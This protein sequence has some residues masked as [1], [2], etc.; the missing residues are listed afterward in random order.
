MSELLIGEGLRPYVDEDGLARN[1]ADYP[2]MKEELSGLDIERLSVVRE[3]LLCVP[4][5]HTFMDKKLIGEIN[6]GGLSSSKELGNAA[7]THPIDTSL[8]LDEYVFASWGE[9]G[10]AEYGTLSVMLDTAKV[11]EGSIVTPEDICAYAPGPNL[12]KT[13]SEQEPFFRKRIDEMYLNKMV[14]GND[15][16]EITAR[17][18]ILKLATNQGAYPP[19]SMDQLAL[20]EI[21]YLNH[22]PPQYLDGTI[23]IHVVNSGNHLTVGGF[24]EKIIGLGFLSSQQ[25][26]DLTWSRDQQIRDAALEKQHLAANVWRK[27]L[28]IK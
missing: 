14:S 12:Q 20:G 13:Y 17:K 8:G 26:K 11:L 15:W 6:Y 22:I 23:N 5:V 10:I 7:N 18:I 27:L 2:E 16:L 1:A 4:V 9:Q 21:K 24:E 28:D 3:H 19:I 25:Q